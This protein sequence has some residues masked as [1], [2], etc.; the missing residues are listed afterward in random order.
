MVQ[1]DSSS[2]A[3]LQ[4][5]GEASIGEFASTND[6]DEITYTI[7]ASGDKEGKQELIQLMQSL[8]VPVF[9]RLQTFTKEM[10]RM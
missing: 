4:V 1:G 10:Q 3:W 2:I 7:T 8:K 9:E 6:E 5:T